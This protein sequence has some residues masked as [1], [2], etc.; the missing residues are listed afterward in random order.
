MLSSGRLTKLVTI[1]EN[2]RLVTQNIDQ[3][4]PIA[5]VESTTLAASQIFEEDLNRSLL[6]STDERPEQTERIIHALG[7]R[8]AGQAG[9]LRD[10]IVEKHHTAQ[11]MLQRM[12]V[13][14]PFAPR[15]AS[16]FLADRVEARRGFPHLMNM[17][18]AVA[19]LHQFQ[20]QI[21]PQGRLRA[22]LDDYQVARNLLSGP[23]GRLLGRQLSEAA[24]RYRDR[25]SEWAVGMESFTSTDASKRDKASRRS[26]QAWLAE[27]N[28]HG[29]VE[30]VEPHKGNKPAKWRLLENDEALLGWSLPDLI[31]EGGTS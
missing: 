12:S 14:I 6:L 4:G 3:P 11:R 25:L 31:G 1:K 28:D 13:V 2:G 8:Y 18:Q 5:Y 23:L 26:V 29:H 17:V 9:G 30:L 15:L 24:A 10:R 16:Q 7:E 22:T 20:R 27:L 21:D 19:L